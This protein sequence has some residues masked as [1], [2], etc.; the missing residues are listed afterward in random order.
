MINIR[1]TKKRWLHFLS[2]LDAAR[3][4]LCAVDETHKRG[5]ENRMEMTRKAYLREE[6]KDKMCM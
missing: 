4:M 2:V 5:I 3:S 1:R 6:E